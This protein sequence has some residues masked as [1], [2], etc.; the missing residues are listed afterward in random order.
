MT[1]HIAGTRVDSQQIRGSSQYDAKSPVRAGPLRQVADVF[2]FSNTE[3]PVQSE[4]HGL[5]LVMWNR[6][7]KAIMI[8]FLPAGEF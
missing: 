2:E 8:D 3:G 7:H 5:A 6:K 1:G 4:K